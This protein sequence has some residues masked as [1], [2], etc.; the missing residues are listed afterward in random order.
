EG[1]RLEE[2]PLQLAGA[3][4]GRIGVLSAVVADP[5]VGTGADEVATLAFVKD[6]L[7]HG[8]LRAAISRLGAGHA[9]GRTIQCRSWRGAQSVT[10]D[11]G[12]PY[13]LGGQFIDDAVVARVNGHDRNW[14]LLLGLL[15]L[16]FHGDNIGGDRLETPRIDAEET[17][18]GGSLCV[19]QALDGAGRGEIV[20]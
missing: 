5:I 9:F 3:W 15:L 19:G 18:C 8:A 13:V 16:R 17:H 2:S 20:A 4:P 6:R 14:T 1:M 12:I 7:D 11:P 10:A